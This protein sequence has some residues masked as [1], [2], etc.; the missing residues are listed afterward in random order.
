MFNDSPKVSD[1]TKTDI[2]QLNLSQNDEKEG[3]EAAV[4]A[5]A[6]FGIRYQV[7]LRSLS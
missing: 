3:E 4:Q 7:D 1:L 5:S 2:F 6:V